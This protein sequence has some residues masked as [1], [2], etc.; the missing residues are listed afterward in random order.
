MLSIFNTNL[1]TTASSMKLWF[2]KLPL[3]FTA[4]N[5]CILDDI[6]T[7]FNRFSIEV[8]KSLQL[9]LGAVDVVVCMHHKPK[10]LGSILTDADN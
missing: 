9:G 8:T 3:Q 5:K 2:Q 7:L 1:I 6:S 10:F 4:S